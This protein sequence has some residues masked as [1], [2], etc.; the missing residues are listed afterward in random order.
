MGLYV[1]FIKGPVYMAA[2]RFGWFTRSN[3]AGDQGRGK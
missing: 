3:G 1:R 2:F